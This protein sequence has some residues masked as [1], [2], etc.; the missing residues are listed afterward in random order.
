MTAAAAAVVMVLVVE[1]CSNDS[2][3]SS[4][5]C[6]SETVAHAESFLLA[7]LWGRSLLRRELESSG[8]G[9]KDEELQ[10]VY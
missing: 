1:N 9:V 4:E 2:L 3:V 10:F 7:S 8:V 6:G 5:W